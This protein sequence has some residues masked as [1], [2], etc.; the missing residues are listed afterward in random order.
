MTKAT[1]W[2]VITN[3][4]FLHRTLRDRDTWMQEIRQALPEEIKTL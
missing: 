4:D 1:T 2:R 3:Q